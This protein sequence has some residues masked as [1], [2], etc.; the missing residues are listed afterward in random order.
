MLY[1]RQTGE[2]KLMSYDLL[3]QKAIN[4]HEHGFLTEAE[5]IYRQI[6][7]TAPNNPDVLNLLGLV[8][9]AKGIN[10]QAV[11]LFY[12]AINHEPNNPA[13]YFNLAL[14]LD[15]WGKPYEAI[16]NYRKAL[17]NDNNIKEAYN[18][19]GNIYKNLNNIP[20]ATE[21]YQKAINIDKN[22]A[23][24]QANL[25]MLHN[26]IQTLK[27]LCQKFPD[28]ALSFYFLSQV[29]YAQTEYIQ[30]LTYI[31][32]ADIICPNYDNIK[33]QIGYILL[34]QNKITEAKINFEKALIY[35]PNSLPALINLGNIET[36]FGN[37]EFAEKHYKKALDLA[38]KELN[39]HANY[40][41]MLYLSKRLPE[42]L[43]EYRKA[44]IINPN[45]AEISNNLGIILKDLEEYEEAL[46][47]FF[48]ALLKQPEREEFSINIAETLVLL[49][50]QNPENALKIAQN[51]LKQ[52]SENTFAQHTLASLQG[53]NIADSKIYSEKLFDHFADNYELV[54]QR[55]GYS[56]PRSFRNLI[57]DVK[58]TIV[59]IGCGSGLIGEA[60]KTDSTTIIGVDISEKM[61][62]KARIKGCY[63]ELIKSDIGQ[64]LKTKPQADLIIAADVFVYIGNLDEI[65]KDCYPTKLA[66]SIEASQNSNNYT[67]TASGRYQHNP[68]YIEKLLQTNGYN[69]IEKH[70]LVLRK[71]NNQDVNGMIFIAR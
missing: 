15:A 33:I 20:L 41:N 29:Y 63:Q 38:P 58:G 55:I 2:I 68:D 22:Y 27:Q 28:D 37:F 64:Y 44:V 54:L 14:S 30:A 8:A 61:L 42:A 5:Q 52:N 69:K 39:A 19:I 57:V 62:E 45:V 21:N 34:A 56:L 13:F 3:F 9:Q 4:L 16:D 40:A 17:S 53:E 60:F 51:W 43:E 47:L 18:N 32:Q 11:S 59:D 65:I 35:N 48:N 66:F 50:R 71:E 24:A 26:D 25:A 67:L 12:Q 70:N 49:H 1:A 7:E 6:L 36:N 10:N 46:G 31:E 23:E